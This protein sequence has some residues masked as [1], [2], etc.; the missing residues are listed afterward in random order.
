MLPAAAGVS[1]ATVR[2]G[3]AGL[4]PRSR[5]LARVLLR[6]RL[7]EREPERPG[8]S[9]RRRSAER[10]RRRSAEAARRSLDVG[11]ATES[12][13]SARGGPSPA[14]LLTEPRMLLPAALLLTEPRSRRSAAYFEARA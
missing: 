1:A 2:S 5:L 10:W 8:D 13:D 9:P 6:G 11:R 4:L 12:G 14:A 7:L 3:R